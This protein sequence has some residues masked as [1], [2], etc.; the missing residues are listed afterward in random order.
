MAE[1]RE[2]KYAIVLTIDDLKKAVKEANAELKSV[3]DETEKANQKIKESQKALETYAVSVTSSLTAAAT[4]SVNMANKF[5]EGF[6]RVA[7]LIPGA[8]ARIKELQ[9]NVLELS[10][11]V[12]KTTQDLT[13]GLYEIISGFGDSADSAK[14]LTLAAKAA[15]A[16]SSTTKEAIALLSAVT[17][18]YGDTSLDAQK[19]VS[20]LAFTTLKLGQTSMSELASSIQKTTS[21]SKELGVTQEELFSVFASGTGVIGGAAEVATKLQAAYTELMKPGDALLEAFEKLGVQTGAELIQ[22][23]GGLQ[24]AF[25]ALKNVADETGVAVNTLFGSA[26]AGSLVLYEAGAGAAKATASFEAM[27]NVVGATDEA[28]AETTEHGVNSFGFQLQQLQLNAQKMAIKLGQE[29]IPALQTL[30]KPVMSIVNLLAS[31]SPGW[32]ALIGTMTKSAVAMALLTTALIGYNKVKATAIKLQGAFNKVLASNPYGVAAVAITGVIV[33]LKGLCD[34]L[35]KAKQKAHEATIEAEKSKQKRYEEISSIQEKIKAWAELNAVMG[36]SEKQKL[37]QAKLEKEILEKL[38][39]KQ[40]TEAAANKRKSFEELVLSAKEK[41]GQLIAEEQAHRNA[42]NKTEKAIE[43]RKNAI[44]AKE[45]KANVDDIAWQ[46]G[47]AANVDEVIKE[48]IAAD[49]E[50][51]NLNETLAKQNETLEK[52]IEAKATLN[53]LNKSWFVAESKEASTPKEKEKPNHESALSK[54]IAEQDDRL[55]ALDDAYKREAVIIEN[56]NITAAQKAKEKTEAENKYFNDRLKLLKT[57][58]NERMQAGASYEEA[59]SQ[60]L[61]IQNKTI[62]G[63]VETT[64]DN[65]ARIAKEKLEAELPEIKQIAENAKASLEAESKNKF[66]AGSFGDKNASDSKR[67][68]Y[69]FQIAEYDTKILELNEQITSLTKEDAEANAEKINALKGEVSELNKIKELA[70]AALASVQSTTAEAAQKAASAIQE[71]GQI[72]T[73]TLNGIANLATDIIGIKQ[74]QNA[75]RLAEQLAEIEREKNETLMELENEYLDWKEEKQ[76]EAQEREEARAAAEYEKQQEQLTRTLSETQAAFNQETNIQKAKNKEN[77]LEEKRRALAEAQQKKAEADAEKKRQKEERTQ[78]IEML[79]TKA[80]AQWQFQVATIE[81]QNAAAQSDAAFARQ[82]AQWQKAQSVT[83]LIVQTAINTATAAAKI[84]ESFMNPAAIPSAAAYTVAAAISAAQIAVVSAAPIP[85]GQATLAPLP[86]A[87]RPIK[88]ARGGIVYPSAGGAAFNL[89]N[90]TPAVA[91]EAGIP[92]IILPVNQQ[93]LEA[94]FK[95]QGI[96]NNNNANVTI[97]PTYQITVMNEQGENAGEKILNEL[98]PYDRELLALVENTKRMN[99]I[100]D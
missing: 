41:T 3:A 24:G 53:D 85:S 13:D 97:A 16:G 6:S 69:R 65:I 76:L 88:F 25:N 50:L 8:T 57:F 37:E 28:F 42:I 83:N 35:E 19:K 68:M 58:I 27:Q 72:A 55:K 51:K 100:G 14:T 12:G 66:D 46:T 17:K 79:N 38:D 18:G 40:D 77:E 10:P 62:S 49:K 56:S 80:Q 33:A 89:Q 87:P 39:V 81:A 26:Q 45:L 93:N 48:K 98:R 30:L 47:T 52:I 70:A 78:E 61:A 5:N 94:V 44:K 91:A 75:E 63:E 11:A 36:K 60:M 7:T 1:N 9:E 4:A 96:T 23:F 22:K 2:L 71:Y 86:P 99:Y 64:Y 31:A 67:A 29:L 43:N 54:Q 32:M 95:A 21:S 90:G 73:Q 20:D 82:T 84:A 15:A 92:E 34:W 74:K 59:V